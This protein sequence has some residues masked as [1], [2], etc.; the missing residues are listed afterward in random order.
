MR[1]TVLASIFSL[2]AAPLLAQTPSKLPPIKL[3]I[4]IPSKTQTA[5]PT[6]SQAVTTLSDVAPPDSG[7]RWRV[8]PIRF[9]NMYTQQIQEKRN[10]RIEVIGYRNAKR[11]LTLSIFNPSI[12]HSAR[13]R[14]DCGENAR[15]DARDVGIK[16]VNK[17]SY[18]RV[19]VL[20]KASG[21]GYANCS[22]ASDSPI[23]AAAFIEDTVSD[24]ETP[25]SAGLPIQ[26]STTSWPAFRLNGPG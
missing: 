16:E 25:D 1:I 21:A 12:T 6:Q 26:Q 14:V 9:G 23:M 11:S 4:P 18:W 10:G 17:N 19:A 20:P 7:S 8:H 5:T 15:L 13:I 22:I 2:I 3:P 24:K